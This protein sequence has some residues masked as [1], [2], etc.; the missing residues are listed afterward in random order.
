VR[1]AP[2]RILACKTEVRGKMSDFLCRL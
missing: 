1:F 2:N